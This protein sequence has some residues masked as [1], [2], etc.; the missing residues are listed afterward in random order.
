MR[1]GDALK[2]S[3]V[4]QRRET[5]VTA[6][7]IDQAGRCRPHLIDV[8][9]GGHE[10]CA[11]ARTGGGGRHRSGRGDRSG[12][13]GGLGAG[14]RRDHVVCARARSPAVCC[15]ASVSVVAQAAVGGAVPG[16]MAVTGGAR[17]SAVQGDQGEKAEDQEGRSSG[18]GEHAP[19]IGWPHPGL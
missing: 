17:R 14:T 18:G 9:R 5:V 8:G 15:P 16:A 13:G 4:N 12:G 7:K 3:V 2:L 19:V 10:V 6:L 11:L 1:L